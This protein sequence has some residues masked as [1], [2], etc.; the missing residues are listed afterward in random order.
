MPT[1]LLHLDQFTQLLK[2]NANEDNAI[3]M[4]QYMKNQFLLLGINFP[5]MEKV[6]IIL[7]FIVL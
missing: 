7:L 6:D 1:D 5:Q 4:A 2:H 3:Q